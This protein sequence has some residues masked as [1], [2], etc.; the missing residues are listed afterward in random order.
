MSTSPVPTPTKTFNWS[1]I[2]PSGVHTFYLIL[3]ALGVLAGHVWLQEH[4]ARIAAENTIKVSE[5]NVKSLN[6]Q[7]ATLR[8]VA[9]QKVIVI[10][11]EAATIKDTPTA[12]PVIKAFDPG[13]APTTVAALPDRVEVDSV[14]LA[15]DIEACRIDRVN[16]DACSKELTA[17]KAIVAQ[18]DSEVVALKKKPR[19]WARFK[20]SVRSASFWTTVG[21]VIAKV[22][23]K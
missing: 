12:L 15:K 20:G 21:I 7:I 5:A 23:L 3:I 19:F 13:L 16:L 6:D 17:E 8:S 11:K 22:V 10:Q 4:D 14:T 2:L 9:A 1:S 18:K